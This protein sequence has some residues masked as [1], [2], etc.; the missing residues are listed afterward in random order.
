[1]KMA[2]A[3]WECAMQ[4]ETMY[5]VWN[6]MYCCALPVRCWGTALCPWR[7]FPKTDCHPVA[8][9]Y[10]PQLPMNLRRGL[11][12]LRALFSGLDQ[13]WSYHSGLQ[14]HQLIWVLGAAYKDQYAALFQTMWLV[15]FQP[16]HAQLDRSAWV[17]L[18]SFHSAA[19]PNWP[20]MTGGHKLGC[21]IF[22]Q[23]H[24]RIINASP[25]YKAY[26]HVP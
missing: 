4:L 22:S 14:S 23:V 3:L 21:T 25:H 12:P 7:V 6:C 15:A 2:H 26:L 17:Q 13:P 10:Q 8:F 5:A 16:C 18:G 9:G 19:M 1:L 24:Y 11:S 20:C